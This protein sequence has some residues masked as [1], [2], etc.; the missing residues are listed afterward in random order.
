[1]ASQELRY[2][3]KL[4][5]S[6]ADLLD[7]I[8]KEAFSDADGDDKTE[9]DQAQPKDAI[10][11]VRDKWGGTVADLWDDAFDN[12]NFVD[13]HDGLAPRISEVGL[14]AGAVL[15]IL[16][17]LEKAVRFMPQSQRSLRVIR[18]ELSDSGQRIVGIK[19]PTSDE[20]IVRLMVAMK[21]VANARQ[22]SLDSLS[23]VDEAFS[24]VDT[25][26][27]LWATS[28]RKT[29]KSFFGSIASRASDSSRNTNSNSGGEISQPGKRKG[30][31]SVSPPLQNAMAKKQ[32]SI[33]PANKKSAAPNISSFF[34]VR[35]TM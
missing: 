30:V 34:G 21:E 18:V 27:M 19:F 3:Y 12:S 6:S 4:L 26:A 11:I 16:P 25:K 17:S 32:K 23:F 28:E 10:S 22:G 35:G 14:I 7:S 33:G 1:M 9:K 13:H 31:S 15:H 29:M 5:V 24:P 8:K 20:A 2:K